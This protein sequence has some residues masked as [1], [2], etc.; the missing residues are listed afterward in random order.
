[1]GP[2]AYLRHCD[3][4]LVPF[5]LLPLRAKQERLSDKGRSIYPMNS[6]QILVCELATNTKRG[7]KQMRLL[8]DTRAGAVEL[9]C[10]P[11]F[12][13]SCDNVALLSS[14]IF[15]CR[16][17]CVPSMSA[18]ISASYHC[19]CRACGVDSTHQV[20]VSRLD[21][22]HGPCV[23]CGQTFEGRGHT[24]LPLQ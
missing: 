13:L 20:V 8:G 15:C 14:C 21:Q 23:R 9:P 18:A 4:W 6:L 12:V 10:R 7:L 2:G 16:V 5:Q 11:S 19:S 3:D 17:Y 24:D 1:M 22:H